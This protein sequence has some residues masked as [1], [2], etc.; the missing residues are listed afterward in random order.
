MRALAALMALALAACSDGTGPELARLQV[1]RE[2]EQNEAKWSA[3]GLADYYYAFRRVCDCPEESTAA[4]RID[5]RDGSVYR[6]RLISTGADISPGS[7]FWPTIEELFGEV[8]LALA[9]GAHS[10]QARYDPVY[11]YPL[12]ISIIWTRGSSAG[13][14]LYAGEL[15]STE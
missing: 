13:I 3:H 6:V 8:R 2:L 12:E 4:V 7:A 10:I 14:V 11:G 9:E 5:V 15:M 1:R